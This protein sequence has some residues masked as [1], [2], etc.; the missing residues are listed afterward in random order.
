MHIS[1][2][3]A[4]VAVSNSASRSIWGTVHL[5][6]TALAVPFLVG[7]ILAAFA[8][9]S[10]GE[11]PHPLS[12]AF[13]FSEQSDP[14]GT[15]PPAVTDQ[16]VL[17]GHGS[18]AEQATDL[19]ISG[20]RFTW[21][22]TRC[23]I[24]AAKCPETQQWE[25]HR[26]GTNGDRRLVQESN[27][28]VSLLVSANS[29]RKFS[30]RNGSYI[31][32][33]DSTLL[34]EKYYSSHDKCHFFRLTNTVTGEVDIF[35]DLG[36][37]NSGMLREQTTRDWLAQ[38]K[39]GTR[40]S[41]SSGLI[42]SICTAQGQEYYIAFSY[43]GNGSHAKL[44]K[45]EVKT[46]A[47]GTLLKDVTYTYFA[48]GTHSADVGSDGDLV[49]VRRRELKSGGNPEN[50]VDW[51]VRYT[52]Y[53]YYRNGTSDG[54]VHLLKA[55]FLPDAVQRI[56]DD[57]KDISSAE[58][59]LA[60]GDDDGNSGHH[61]K[62]F[63]SRRFTYYTTNL[64]TNQAVATVWGSENLQAKYGGRQTAEVDASASRHM[65]KSEVVGG[66]SSCGL[67]GGVGRTYYYLDIDHGAKPGVN[68]VV[69]L[70]VED[71]VDANGAGAFRT[72]Y[73]LNK[74][75]RELRE[76]KIVDPAGTPRRMVSSHVSGHS[77]RMRWQ[78]CRRPASSRPWS[79]KTRSIRPG[80][81]EIWA[82]GTPRAAS[83]RSRMV[84]GNDQQHAVGSFDPVHAV[85][86]TVEGEV[87]A[88]LVLPPLEHGVDVLKQGNAGDAGE[89]LLPFD[90]QLV[91]EEG[92]EVEDVDG[93][94]EVLG[95]RTDQGRFA[96]AGAAVQE[97]AAPP[98]DAAGLV[99]VLAPQPPPDLFHHRLGL[100]AEGHLRQGVA[101]V[102]PACPKIARLPLQRPLRRQVAVAG[103]LQ[104]GVPLGQ[105]A[106][107]ADRF[108]GRAE[109]VMD[110]VAGLAAAIAVR[111]EV[112]V[113]S[114][115]VG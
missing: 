16:P 93:Q 13:A 3:R 17:L 4:K 49:Q 60:E 112:V 42:S 79:S 27:N 15:I 14:T 98:G 8:A 43:S 2:I 78:S 103:G 80:R 59:I 90:L 85:Q 105:V 89:H 66:C 57:R 34:L 99:P 44:T 102:H 109:D 58:A 20:P 83:S 25:A 53:R 64:D 50:S 84:R 33:K 94:V 74:G 1:R 19:T 9:G 77:G 115:G 73:G 111:L 63:A 92:C 24:I 18:V 55:V 21:T 91:V 97:P 10:A 37:S 87:A 82:D 108:S 52:Q 36:G 104:L 70:V 72:I 46:S 54:A 88:D 95:D 35:Y 26:L 22:H 71:T 40:Y 96:R 11:Q 32:P 38:D 61:I 56:L 7:M 6:L 51:I 30:Y 23:F 113:L 100:G 106:E 39:V 48:S 45:I 86:E 47:S 29:K 101:V 68:D 65:V 107:E 12:V 81:V 114:Q 41:Y 110:L 28:A 76:A 5:L 62:D 31:A 69:R 67:T 75:E